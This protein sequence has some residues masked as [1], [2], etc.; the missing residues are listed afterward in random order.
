MDMSRVNQAT[1]K[2]REEGELFA[3]TPK[4]EWF[5]YPSVMPKYVNVLYVAQCNNGFVTVCNWNKDN[6]GHWYNFFSLGTQRPVCGVIR[7]MAIESPN[8]HN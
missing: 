8:L 6:R 2:T 5:D 3:E 4:Y 1:G 7:W